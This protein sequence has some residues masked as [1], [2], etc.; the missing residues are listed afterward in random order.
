MRG[1]HS[2]ANLKRCPVGRRFLRLAACRLDATTIQT[3]HEQYGILTRTVDVK[4]GQTTTVEIAYT[5]KEKPST[6]GVI[7]LDLPGD[8][9]AITLTAAR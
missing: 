3:W 8:A 4:A 7:D 5:G 2:D 1:W 9:A 6:A